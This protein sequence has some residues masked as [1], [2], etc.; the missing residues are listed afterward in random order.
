MQ[1]FSPKM[2]KNN[3][4]LELDNFASD[5]VKSLPKNSRIQP[6]NKQQPK[7]IALSE[8]HGKANTFVK[9]QS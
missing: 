6:T 8:N 5:T 9:I 1:D 2:K 7:Y 4:L 3:I